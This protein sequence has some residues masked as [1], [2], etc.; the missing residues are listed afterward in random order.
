DHDLARRHLELARVRVVLVGGPPGTGKSTLAGGL[1]DR[2]GWTVLSTDEVRK[3]VLGIPRG[4]HVYTA[5]GKGI[6]APETTQL[7][8]EELLRRAGQ[9]L[10][11]GESVVLD[12]SG[13]SARNRADARRA[14]WEHRADVVEVRCDLPVDIARE[15][16]ARR[17]AEGFDLSDATPEVVTDLA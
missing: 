9:L 5:P 13:A 1:A 6:Y 12:A 2:M 10:A 17:M 15:R 8:Y 4:R 14:G 7:V 3:D 11:R 16:V